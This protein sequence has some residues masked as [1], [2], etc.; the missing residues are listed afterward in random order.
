MKEQTK[1]TKGKASDDASKIGKANATKV[2]VLSPRVTVCPL[3]GMPAFM[4]DKVMDCALRGLYKIITLDG[5][6]EALTR[7]FKDLLKH[8][9]ADLQTPI[10]H[11]GLPTYIVTTPRRNRHIKDRS[12]FPAQSVHIGFRIFNE[13][14]DMPTTRRMRDAIFEAVKCKEQLVY[15]GP[16][17][18]EVYLVC[19]VQVPVH[20]KLPALSEEEVAE[21]GQNFERRA[22]K[23]TFA[24]I[25]VT[26]ELVYLELSRALKK[27]PEWKGTKQ[28]C[29][30]LLPV[31]HDSKALYRKEK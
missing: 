5:D 19:T 24:L 21:H 9:E 10:E 16:R 28:R 18:G 4:Q 29:E 22:A 12:I 8:D 7:K 3:P 15:A 17:P 20:T 23:F 6:I 27:M 13:R 25:E 30:I 26:Q 1:T 2:E 31:S 11:L 14:W